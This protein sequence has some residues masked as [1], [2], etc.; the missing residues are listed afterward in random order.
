MANIQDRV[1]EDLKKQAQNVAAALGMEDGM[2]RHHG[3][4][5]LSI[6]GW[7]LLK[8][9]I[10]PRMRRQREHLKERTSMSIMRLSPANRDR[11]IIIYWHS[12]KDAGFWRGI[13]LGCYSRSRFLFFRWFK[14]RPMQNTPQAMHMT[15]VIAPVKLILPPKVWAPMQTKNTMLPIKPP[16]MWFVWNMPTSRQPTLALSSQPARKFM[17]ALICLSVIAKLVLLPIRFGLWMFA[18]GPA[19]NEFNEW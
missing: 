7:K 5:M 18:V 16:N 9:M 13:F 1:D 15:S 11:A 3:C 14:Y 10:M 4:A 6:L 17:L 2:I 8:T 19:C 12:Q